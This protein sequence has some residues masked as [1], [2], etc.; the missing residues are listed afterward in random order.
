MALL[1]GFVALS[2]ARPDPSGGARRTCWP[3]CRTGGPTRPGS[4]TPAPRR[5]YL[6]EE[7]REG[8]IVFSTGF[9]AW[10]IS[11]FVLEC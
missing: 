6:R 7:I 10:F 9:A 1:V 5:R 11:S 2:S 8:N 3:A 4:Q